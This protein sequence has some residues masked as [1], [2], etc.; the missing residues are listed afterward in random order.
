[1]LPIA[2]L[3]L[4]ALAAN[5]SGTLQTLVSRIARV[6]GGNTRI[7]AVRETGTLES[8]RGVAR[9]VRVFA[10]P[11]RLR[12]EILYPGGDG[13]VR[14]LDGR[15]GWRN[16]EPVDGPPRDAMVL[17]AARLD[18]PGILLRNRELL[19]DLGEVK[20]DGKI[21]RAIGIPTPGNL[22]LAIT[23]DPKTGRIVRSEG[24]MPMGGGQVRFATDYSDFRT[25]HGALFAFHEANFASGQKTGETRLEKIELLD[26]APADAFRP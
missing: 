17:Q 4:F 5:G 7:H 8:S 1:M 22:N 6:Y 3:A 10:A 26:S 19:V 13:E 20:R 24:A 21:F 23:V 12:I 11:D 16:G 2:H 14:V 18:V 9:T 25:V 15:Q